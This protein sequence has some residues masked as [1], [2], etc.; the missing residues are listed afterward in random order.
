VMS[1]LTSTPLLS[2]MRNGDDCRIRAIRLRVANG[3]SLRGIRGS[4]VPR[5]IA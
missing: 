1:S 5:N 3:A 2:K 4:A